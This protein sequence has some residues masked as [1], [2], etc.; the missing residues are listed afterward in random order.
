MKK[1]KKIAIILLSFLILSLFL[2]L[3]FKSYKKVEIKSNYEEEVV[4][5][6][7]KLESIH[8]N[9]IFIN[10][11]SV[12]LEKMPIV[13]VLARVNMKDN[14]LN[15]EDVKEI[16][17]FLFNEDSRCSEGL[18]GPEQEKIIIECSDIKENDLVLVATKEPVVEILDTDVF[19]VIEAKR[20]I[21][22]D[23]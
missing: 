12:D 10:I 22:E 14:F 11:D 13:D 3:F 16:K 9:S 20:I 5:E 1:T 15:Q 8:K 4:E 19:N 6:K 23:I 7:I 18:M 17:K 2:L 21:R